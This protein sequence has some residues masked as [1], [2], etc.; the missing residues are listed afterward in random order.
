MVINKIGNI[1]NIIEPQKNRNVRAK[2]KIEK[3]DSINISIEGKQAAEIAK[4]QQIV[5]EAPD[6]RSEKVAMLKEQI[7][8]GS[9]DFD[10]IGKLG[11]VAG[12]ISDILQ[13]E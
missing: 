6:V 2:D 12:K 11:V 3:N 4:Y 7:E 9:Y 13:A 1:N 5:S 10:D 8:N